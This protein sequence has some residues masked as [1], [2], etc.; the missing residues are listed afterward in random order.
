MGA[1][2]A[3][4][5]SDVSVA[6][7]APASSVAKGPPEGRDWRGRKTMEETMRVLTITE[8]M[9]LTRTEL[10]GLFTQITNE[11]PRFPEGSPVRAMFQAGASRFLT[12][13]A[14][15]TGRSNRQG[16]CRSE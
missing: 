12:L 8:L 9:R 4:S 3:H 16:Q 1:S 7:D 15:R 5:S 14:Q 11:L 13:V 10:C 2:A 6:G